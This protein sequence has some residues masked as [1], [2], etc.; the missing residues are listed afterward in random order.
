MLITEELSPAISNVVK[1]IQ[2]PG[3][4]LVFDFN[5]NQTLVLLES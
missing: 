3:H 2:L 5:I 4:F 1:L